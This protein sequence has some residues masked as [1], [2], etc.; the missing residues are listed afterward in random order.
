MVEAVKDKRLDPDEHKDPA[1][2]QEQPEEAVDRALRFW[3]NPS[4]SPDTRNAL[5]QFAARCRAGANRAW[6]RDTY[7]LLCQNAL[8]TMIATSPDLYTC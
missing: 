4:L 6:K 8:R 7:P 5:E 3:G 2:A 1:Y